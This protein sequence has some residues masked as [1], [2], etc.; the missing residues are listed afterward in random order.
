[1]DESDF[2]P[3]R[4]GQSAVALLARLVKQRPQTEDVVVT[5][6]DACLP[7]FIVQ[8]EYVEGLVDVGRAGLADRHT[9][10]ALAVRSIRR[11]LGARWVDPFLDTYGRELVDGGK[12][13]YYAA[14]DELA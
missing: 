12:L 5:H 11:N 7:N 9:D 8:G 14:L 6:G 2:D 3:G 4:Q 1:M 13:E 10:L